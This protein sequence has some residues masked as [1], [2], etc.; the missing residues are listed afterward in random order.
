MLQAL[1]K[2]NFTRIKD[3]DIVKQD[4]YFNTHPF[5]ISFILG[6]W[7]K[8]Y[9]RN[10]KPD[11][12]KK[13]YASAFAALGDSFIWHSLRPF[14][15]VISAIICIYNPYLGFLFY[16]I[17]FNIFHFIFLY[18]G[19]D[20][21][22]E[23]GREVINW[24]NRIKFNKWSGY[25][26]IASAFLLGLFLSKLIQTVSFLDIK[27]YAMATM[28][29][30]VGFFIGKTIDILHGLIFCIVVVALIAYLSGV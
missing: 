10:G 15:F 7:V 19:Y 24:F 2:S 5:F 29:L 16:L 21:G 14:C 30:F 27:F 9:E 1:N 4:D 6:V 25:F 11:Y 17:F 28:F 13:T 23:F 18:A 8:E 22:Y 26:D 20:V 12:F 3:E